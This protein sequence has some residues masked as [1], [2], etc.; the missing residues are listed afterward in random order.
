MLHSL[1]LFPYNKTNNTVLTNDAGLLLGMPPNLVGSNLPNLQQCLPGLTDT[2]L[3]HLQPAY[4]ITQ[5]PP[6]HCIPQP[7]QLENGNGQVYP[8]P[9][10]SSLSH[11][12]IH[13]PTSLFG[14]ITTPAAT[15]AVIAPPRVLVQQPLKPMTI[16]D[17]IPLPQ[18]VYNGSDFDNN[19]VSSIFEFIPM[20]K[21]TDLTTGTSSGHLS[22]KKENVFPEVEE[23]KIKTPAPFEPVLLEE[24]LPQPNPITIAKK[25]VDKPK[26]LITRPAKIL[27]KRGCTG[28]VLTLHA[29]FFPVHVAQMPIYKYSLI[30]TPSVPNEKGAFQGVVLGCSQALGHFVLH[31]DY[32]YCAK[33]FMGNARKLFSQYEDNTYLVTLIEENGVGNSERVVVINKLLRKLLKALSWFQAGK[34]Y[35]SKDDSYQIRSLI[36]RSGG[37]SV[38]PGFLP[39]VL[40][41]ETDIL[42][43]VDLVHMVIR[44]DTA[45]ELYQ[46]MQS[47]SKNSNAVFKEAI[48][49]EHVVTMYNGRVYKVKDVTFKFN[50]MTEFNSNDG[51]TT[52]VHF[53]HQKYG[54][55]IVNKKQPLLMAHILSEGKEKSVVYLVPELCYLT[56]FT[57]ENRRDFFLMRNIYDEI[58]TTP[59]VGQLKVGQ[60]VKTFSEAKNEKVQEILREWKLSFGSEMVSFKGRH[61]PAELAKV[62]SGRNP[63]SARNLFDWSEDFRTYR[64]LHCMPIKKWA[65]LV[66]AQHVKASDRFII[67]LQSTCAALGITLAKPF[68]IQIESDEVN[69]YLRELKKLFAKERPQIVVFILACNR[70]DKYSAIKKY[71]TVEHGVASQVLTVKSMDQK[72]DFPVAKR[73]AV[74]LNCK[75]GGTPWSVEVPLTLGMV[76]GVDMSVD[77]R[78]RNS[79][80]CSVVASF[81][82]DFS[83]FHSATFEFAT[84]DFEQM[85]VQLCEHVTMALQNFKLQHHNL[86]KVIILYRDGVANRKLQ[87]IF[88]RELPLMQKWLNEVYKGSEWRLTYVVVNKHS[89]TKIYANGNANP[90]TGTVVDTCITNPDRYDFLLLSG[91]TQRKAASFTHYNVLFDNTSL[92]PD[93]L[94]RLTY[95]MTHLYFNMKGTVR[96]PAPLRYASRLVAVVSNILHKPP[97]PNLSDVLHF[98]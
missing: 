39:V 2:A 87:H 35:F 10:G 78:N 19:G 53:Y 57:S 73:L 13:P 4:C 48:V 17:P 82:S 97:H 24:C 84:G 98:L 93:R 26:R 21:K 83:R 64:M 85:S 27:D 65:V 6:A 75:V 28:T 61:L 45:F 30:I 47:R 43:N 59:K 44:P 18:D 12:V 31:Y 95:K 46:V 37:W 20:P 32:I 36:E 62:R 25:P 90:P 42:F 29:N 11:A 76:I 1:G 23:R 56:G 51:P 68:I 16:M 8:P 63:S 52:F 49:G 40:N 7:I 94:Q 9:I 15:P 96:V 86:P 74:Q 81:D 88:H 91:Q 38:K 34:V 50:P 60:F 66:P 22:P 33:K 70:K 58:S 5:T 79:T 89:N 41:C 80:F 71:C 67:C 14:G 92:T 77:T 55:S 54:V 69:C 3:W 72:Y